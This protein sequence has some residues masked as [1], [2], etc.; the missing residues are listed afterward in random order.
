M[1]QSRTAIDLGTELAMRIVALDEDCP[2][3]DEAEFMMPAD[4]WM[5]LVELSRA[6]I[7]AAFEDMSGGKIPLPGSDKGG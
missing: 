7:V 5:P 4:A 1:S 6:V 2:G 3:D